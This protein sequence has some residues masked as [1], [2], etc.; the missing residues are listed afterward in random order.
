MLRS[1]RRAAALARRGSASAV[2]FGAGYGV[3]WAQGREESAEKLAVWAVAASAAASVRS[4]RHLGN[5]I[6]DTV[7][8]QTQIDK[9][10]SVELHYLC[11][12]VD[13][14]REKGL[15]SPI[16]YQ[17]L[18]SVL[19]EHAEA[20]PHGMAVHGLISSRGTGRS[21][22]QELALRIREAALSCEGT[23]SPVHLAPT[24]SRALAS[25][26]AELGAK[27]FQELGN[28]GIV[29]LARSAVVATA[30]LAAETTARYQG[31]RLN[32]LTEEEDLRLAQDLSRVWKALR[33]ASA[34]VRSR[35]RWTLRAQ[36]EPLKGRLPKMVKAAVEEADAALESGAG[37]GQV[38]KIFEYV[39]WGALVIFLLAVFSDDG[40]GFFR[41]HV[42]P[43]PWQALLKEKLKERALQVEELMGVDDPPPRRFHLPP[44]EEA[45]AVI[46]EFPVLTE[47]ALTAH[48]VST[49]TERPETIGHWEA[50]YMQGPLFRGSHG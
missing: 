16:L 31:L 28:D 10:E 42:V 14:C 2:I 11:A 8:P 44:R 32:T 33:R 17:L 40:L 19:C 34:G 12:F 24:L 48:T 37:P 50:A 41:F 21:T 27:E 49:R 38:G 29:N 30:W 7:R 35:D 45:P 5:S 46:D 3:C 25:L 26:L 43:R 39:S 23:I 47:A 15:D 6:P 9:V 36:L 4:F 22:F 13:T 1:L 20:N 18:L